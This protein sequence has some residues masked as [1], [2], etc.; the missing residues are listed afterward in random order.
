MEGNMRSSSDDDDGL[1]MLDEDDDDDDDDD[2]DTSKE[3]GLTKFGG[4][5]DSE[6]DDEEE[7]DDEFLFNDEESDDSDA[8][9]KV[10]DGKSA[11]L[12]QLY[13]ASDGYAFYETQKSQTLKSRNNRFFNHSALKNETKR[14]KKDDIFEI[15]KEKKKKDKELK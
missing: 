14:D 10:N 2:D 12:T 7:G 1:V 11:L 15:I 4:M 13:S 6:S 8:L 3:R 5:I 9:P